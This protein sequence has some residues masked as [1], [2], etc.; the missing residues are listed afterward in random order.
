MRRIARVLI[1]GGGSSGWMTAAYLQQQL[2]TEVQ[3]TLI[4]ASDIPIIGVGESTNAVMFHFARALGLDEKSLL[5]ASNG[6]FKVGIRFCNFNRQGGVFYHPFGLPSGDGM[7]KPHAERLHAPFQF[8]ERGNEFVRKAGHAYQL[9]AGLFGEYLKIRSRHKGVR[10][11]VDRIERVERDESGQIARL[12][13]VGSGPLEAD[14]YVDCSGFGSL[15]LDKALQEPFISV[16]HQLLNDRAIA[17]RVQYV[18]KDR[19]LRTVTNC[20]GVSSGWVWE[21]PLW[22]RI[23]TGYVYSSAYLSQTDAEAEFRTYLGEQ[24]VKDVE[25]NHIRIR[26]GR[27]ERAWVGNCVAIGIS[28]GFLEPLESTGLSLTQLMIFDL[29]AALAADGSSVAR[30]TFNRRQAELF[31]T[32]KDFILAH[33]VLTSRDDT[34]Y[35]RHIKYDCPI[36]DSLNDILME[37]RQKRYALIE[38]QVNKFYA[39]L[40]WNLILS[41]MG[42]FDGAEPPKAP[43]PPAAAALHATFLKEHI[44]DGD[45][46]EPQSVGH[47]GPVTL[48]S[49]APT[50]M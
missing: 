1:V 45:Y 17:A 30:S 23:G 26:A 10:H 44:Y 3:I 38:G 50:W 8:A 43:M 16:N 47:R 41:G 33:Y 28:Y 35:W 13:T 15:L 29:A 2:G 49:W 9:D 19:E 12:H 34:P 37:A 48:P 20:V 4:E 22:S 21:I 11:V 32:T 18:D 42:W 27:H 46:Q 39:A 7:F 24:R 14:L 40:N 25:F 31:D 6:A 36:P 5:R